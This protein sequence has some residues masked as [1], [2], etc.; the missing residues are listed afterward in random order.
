M[1]NTATGEDSSATPMRA[2]ICYIFGVLFP[3]VYLFSVK[4]GD[5]QP[6]LRFHSFQSLLLFGIWL[7]L[8]IV[9]FRPGWPQESAGIGSLLCA[10]AWL[11]SYVQAQRRKRF[12]L[13]VLGIMAEALSGNG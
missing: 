6:L 12:H 5:Q 4:H 7:P 1:L 13:P 9:H 10:I 3:L 11:A 8:L 2:G